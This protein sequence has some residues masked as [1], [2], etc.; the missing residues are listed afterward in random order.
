M[1]PLALHTVVVKEIAD[2]LRHPLLDGER[3][4]LYLGS[5]APDIRVIALCDRQLT[6]F[7][8]LASFEEQNGMAE[9][10]RAHPELAEVGKLNGETVAFMAGYISHLVMDETWIN[11]IYRPFFGERSPL[12]GEPRA[13]LMD[14][15]GLSVSNW[16]R[17]HSRWRASWRVTVL[18]ALTSTANRLRSRRFSSIRSISR[19]AWSR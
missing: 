9:L 3:G 16:C 11:D 13:K 12:E 19:L 18:D 15:R 6:H 10:L 7:F 4:N 5:T 8:D 1:P 17:N 2:R 14:R